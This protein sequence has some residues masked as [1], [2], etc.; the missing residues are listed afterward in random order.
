MTRRLRNSRVLV[1]GHVLT[2]FVPLG[3]EV[4]GFGSSRDK[5]VGL[6]GASEISLMEGRIVI[7]GS[8]EVEQISI[9]LAKVFGVEYPDVRLTVSTS[10]TGGWFERFTKGD[11]DIPDASRPIESSE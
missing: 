4:G 11:I 8:S 1:E 10:C 6:D 7:Y 5:L 9:A 2:G 3:C